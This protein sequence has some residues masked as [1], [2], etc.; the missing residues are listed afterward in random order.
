[1]Q[2]ESNVPNIEEEVHKRL[3]QSLYP[4]VKRLAYNYRD[5]ALTLIGTVSSVHARRMAEELVKDLEGI[6]RVRNELV[7]VMPPEDVSA[8]ESKP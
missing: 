4:E 8:A 2:V 7:V 1:M 3:Q 5:G 6:E